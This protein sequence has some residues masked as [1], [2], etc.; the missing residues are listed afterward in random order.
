MAER[1]KSAAL[2]LRIEPALKRALE[3][4]AKADGRTV[5]GYIEQMIREKAKEPKR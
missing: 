4:L 5:T 1:I 3:R 2:S